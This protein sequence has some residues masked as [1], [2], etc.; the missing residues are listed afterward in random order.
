MLIGLLAVIVVAVGIIWTLVRKHRAAWGKSEKN[1][2]DNLK[3]AHHHAYTNG[4]ADCQFE[5]RLKALLKH[6]K[7]NPIP[8]CVTDCVYGDETQF[9]E[10]ECQLCLQF[11]LLGLNAYRISQ[12]DIRTLLKDGGWTKGEKLA[13]LETFAEQFGA[14]YLIFM[15]YDAYEHHSSGKGWACIYGFQQ[16]GE[17]ATYDFHDGAVNADTAKR[18]ISRLCLSSLIV[19]DPSRFPEITATKSAD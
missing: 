14:K 8:V 10:A 7:G 15:G 16:Q 11:A 13:V 9:A 18:L 12:T 5:I 4:R 1:Y 6:T 19:R 2:E 3:N 17:V